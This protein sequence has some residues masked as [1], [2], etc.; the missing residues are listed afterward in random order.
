MPYS[1][2]AAELATTA[3]LDALRTEVSGVE[4]PMGPEGPAGP[5]GL[6]GAPGAP[7]ADGAPGLPG[8]DGRD[9]LPGVPGAPG[10]PGADGKDGTNG[11][12]IPVEAISLDEPRWGSGSDDAKLD[13]CLSYLGAQTN[14]RRYAIQQPNRDVS[15][16]ATGR[17]PFTGLRFYGASGRGPKNPE[18]ASAV[19]NRIKLAVGNGVN[20]WF[21]STE[22]IY[23]VVFSN[24]CMEYTNSVGQFWN[25]PSGT[26]YASE[27]HSM[28]HFGA[29]H[30]F[31]NP[32]SKA[33]LTQVITSGHWTV[34]G[35]KGEQFNWGGSDNSFWMSGYLNIASTSVIDGVSKFLMRM[36]GMNKTNVG[37]IYFTCSGDWRGLSI[38]EKS[39]I[40]FFGGA[41]EGKRDTIPCK[42]NIIKVNTTGSA[43]FYGP[44]L[45]FSMSAPDTTE[46]GVI[47]HVNGNLKID[48]PSY[49]PGNTDINVPLVYQTGGRLKVE[50][51]WCDSPQLPRVR[52][53]AGK[54]ILDDTVVQTF[55]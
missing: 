16:S 32:T 26:L 55:A 7:G 28:T 3:D 33:L 54:V 38:E 22:Q 27:F 52:S 6:D 36:R 15:F 18:I 19:P 12:A 11:V 20:S 48:S 41:Y 49:N 14:V 5:A 24:T 31:G 50:D 40:R 29:K 4:G 1:V 43:T 42:G 23:D 51:A 39:N 30:V 8:R 2:E 21:H 10:L 34:L 13:A 9:G 25:Q 17:K 47:E 53:V 35:A 46:H 37:Y 44:W 45:A